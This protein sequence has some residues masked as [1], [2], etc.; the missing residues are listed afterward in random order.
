MRI[1]A[2]TYRGRTIEG[3]PSDKTRP[4]LDRA[5][6]VLFDMLGTR[7]AVPGRLPSIAVLDLFCGTG[8][9]G[10]EALSRGA[11]YC[12]FVEQHRETV[13]VLRHN[14]DVLRVGTGAEI[15]IGDATAGH[16]PPP[17]PDENDAAQYELV[18]VD[19][20]YRMIERMQPT[21]AIRDLLQKLASSAI[22]SPSAII[23]VRHESSGGPRPDLSPLVEADAREVGKMWLRFMVRPDAPRNGA[24]ADTDKDVS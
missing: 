16:F 12:R 23:V 9:I 22:I 10:I 2:G 11:R 8:T 17:P 14:L 7:L 5:K 1:I 20:P 19:P 15:S 4:I 6:T 13:A 18:F 24:S 3:P 21:R